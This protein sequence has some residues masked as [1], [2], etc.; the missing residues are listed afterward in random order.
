MK[1]SQESYDELA[2]YTLLHPSPSFIHQHIVDAFAAQTADEHTKPIKVLFA[3]IGLYLYLERKYTG[4]E[5]QLA[6]MRIGKHKMIW[7]T[8]VLPEH[9]GEITISDVLCEDAGDKR[10]SAI[11]SWCISVWDS[12]S[13]SHKEVKAFLDK[14][15]IK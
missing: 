10:D 11:H 2:S 15:G 3:L 1:S 6:H 8:F 12:Y 14:L 5:V 4:K 9:R 13:A 7:P